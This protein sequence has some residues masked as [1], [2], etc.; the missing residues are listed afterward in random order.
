M[1]FTKKLR[2]LK[3]AKHGPALKS[4]ASWNLGVSRLR[5][6]QQPHHNRA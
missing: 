2:L 6:C 5:R 3:T 4:E 1:I